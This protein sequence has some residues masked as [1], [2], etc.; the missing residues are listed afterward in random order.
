[1]TATAASTG[2]I[3]LSGRVAIVTGAGSGIGREIAKQLAGAGAT[4]VV[5]D[6]IAERAHETVAIIERS[7]GTAVP[8]V[9]DISD[10][11][12]VG[13]FIKRTAEQFGRIDVLCNNAGIM[14]VMS[15]PAATAT[16]VWNRVLA[17]NI[18]GYFFVTRAVLPYMLSRKSGSIVNTASAAGTRGGAAG[19]AY[20]V[21]KHGVVGLTKNIAWA[22]QLDGIRC[23]AICPG[24][25]ET[26]ITGGKGFDMFDPAGVARLMPVLKL[27]T[28]IAQP[29]QMAA[30]ALFLASDAAS[31][32]NGAIIPADGGWSAG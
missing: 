22:H 13:S 8:A 21:S 9:A 23:N 15:E 29:E 4:V 17:V 26:N 20:V 19:L 28:R 11:Q 14:D 6:I 32:V 24:A 16:S 31:F 7:R 18:T 27:A 3:D 30:V 1:M 25:V 2:V 10:E 5:N 12:A